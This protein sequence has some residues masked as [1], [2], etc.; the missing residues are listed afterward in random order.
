[1]ARRKS[2]KSREAPEETPPPKRWRFGRLIK[3]VLGLMILA[4]IGL[5]VGSYF[6]RNE[7]IARVR[8]REVNSNAGVFTRPFPIERSM[9]LTGS[10]TF[11][12][13]ERLAYHKVSGEP[14]H[15]G[16]YS[17]SSDRMLIY[18]RGAHFGGEPDQEEQ[19][20]ELTL[21][22]AKEVTNIIDVKFRQPMKQ[23][24]LEPEL[25]ALLGDTATRASTPKQLK[26]FPENLIHA[27]LAIEDERFYSHFGLDPVGLARAIYVDI[28][29][30]GLVQGGSTIT[31]Q[32]AKNLFFTRE[33]TF[34]R[35]VFEALSAVLVETAFTKDQILELYL[36]EVFLGQEGNVALHGFGEAARAFFGKDVAN[37]TLA[38]AATL[39]GIIKAPTR[40]SPRL[41]PADAKKRR[42]VVLEKMAELGFITPEQQTKA[43]LENI[44]IR[45]AERGKRKAPYFV[46]F[47]RRKMLEHFPVGD[48]A[49]S[50]LQIVTG[51]DLQYQNCADEAV[52]N[53]LKR[54]EQT[55]P[56][57]KKG[58]GPLQAALISVSPVHGEVL[59]WVGGRDYGE[60]Q[61]DR[62][63]QSQR[64][65]GSTFKPFVYLTALDKNLNTYRV[66]RTTSILSDEPTTI[67]ISDGKTWQPKD[68]E[69]GYRG[70]VTVREALTHSLNIPTVQLAMK[71]GIDAVAHTAAL[72]GFGTDLPRVP[73]LALG[74][75]E[76]SPFDLVR[77]YAAIANG[78]T[79]LN[80][81]PILAIMVEGDSEPIGKPETKEERVASEPAVFVL[82]NMLQSVIEAGT[83][84]V[85]RRM[86]FTAPAAGKTGTSSD[87]RDSWFVGFTPRTLAVVWV[88]FD[89]NRETKL[90]GAQ[91]AAPIWTDYMKCV[92]GFEPQ[93]DFVP[94]PGVVFQKIDRQSGLL[95]TPSCPTQNEMTEVFVEGTEPVTPCP[96]H[97][98]DVY[99]DDQGGLP[100]AAQGERE[101]D[102]GVP[103][104]GGSLGDSGDQDNREVLSPPSSRYGGER[105]KG[106]WEM[107]FGR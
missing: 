19:L 10:K 32:L 98:R 41:N 103:R 56:R 83:G 6:I 27:V 82:T 97:T 75:G 43:T 8:E 84:T 13:L 60:N 100:P 57:L 99:A 106:V 107:L 51:L 85:V 29:A 69:E 70:E 30:G 93:L 79:L 50:K 53:G 14:E 76:V 22:P 12:R 90:T 16:E 89:D 68:Y 46:D 39:A 33:R 38:E 72:F 58:K 25:L 47:I 17:L 7:V 88:G 95:M 71:V 52:E 91:G 31:Q 63:S 34:A 81:K 21:S 105:R 35:K 55:Y 9:S 48:P 62:V 74:A 59:A 2:N 26:E 42:A 104:R 61:F 23:I 40:L 80:L 77:A 102:F 18:L 3:G 67:P 86:G 44:D 36:N 64:Q 78:G 73:S 65:P 1:M 87:T 28:T 96:I 4:G 66:A 45:P 37:I 94:P 20:V 101:D 15:A 5:G 11:E 54:L 49:A 24:Y 92:S